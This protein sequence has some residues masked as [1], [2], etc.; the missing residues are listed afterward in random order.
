MLMIRCGRHCRNLDG[1]VLAPRGGAGRLGRYQQY[2]PCRAAY[3][4][5]LIFRT[6]TGQWPHSGLLS[7]GPR[8][9]PDP[10][11]PRQFPRPA[12]DEIE[13]ALVHL[14]AIEHSSHLRVSSAIQED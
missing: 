8:P 10:V 4:G 2:L 11:G 3:S 7:A 6:Y 1:E 12:L 5:D 14:D 13:P 9:V